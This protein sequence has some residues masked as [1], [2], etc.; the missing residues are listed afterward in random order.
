MQNDGESNG[1][2][3]RH[4]N[5]QWGVYGLCTGGNRENI[6]VATDC[7]VSPPRGVAVQDTQ[8]PS[9]QQGIMNLLL[10]LQSSLHCPSASSALA[11]FRHSCRGIEGLAW[12][13]LGWFSNPGLGHGLMISWF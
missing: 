4:V 13:T 2:E 8:L 10:Q 6:V 9:M 1:K 7:D 11:L 12:I 5:G 3:D